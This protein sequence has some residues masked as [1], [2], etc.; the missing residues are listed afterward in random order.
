MQDFSDDIIN[1][2][3]E[4]AKVVP[5][6]N[7]N[8]YRKDEHNAWIKRDNYANTK[9]PLSFGWCIEYI[10]PITSGGHPKIENLRP[11]HWEN[12]DQPNTEKVCG[13]V[14]S[15]HDVNVYVNEKQLKRSLK[16]KKTQNEK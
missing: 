4:K 8:L 11:M 14:T 13:K 2:V 3:W 6:V 12:L 16:E 5:G 7:S 1:R 10:K 15:Y 9:M